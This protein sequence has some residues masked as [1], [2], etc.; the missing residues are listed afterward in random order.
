MKIITSLEDTIDFEEN[1]TGVALG[2]FDGL[3]IGNQT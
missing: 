1:Q 3:H 2:N